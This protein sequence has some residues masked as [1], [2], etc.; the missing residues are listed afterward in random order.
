MVFLIPRSAV[1]LWGGVYVDRLNKRYVMVFT[2]V[3]RAAL[4]A[5]LAIAAFQGSAGILLVY[6]VSFS[7]GLLGA[8]FDLASE[9]ILPSV[10]PAALLLRANS[11]FTAT[12]QVDNI[13]GPAVAGLAISLMGTALPLLF[14]AFSFLALVVALLLMRIQAVAP[15]SQKS[16]WLDD[17]REGWRFFR[18]RPELVW[19]ASLVAGVNFGLGGVWYVYSLIFAKNVLNAG[20]TGWGLI[21]A[22]SALGILASS[23]YIGRVGMKRKRLSVVSSMFGMG[24]AITLLS[25]TQTLPQALVAIAAFG[26]AVPLINVVATTYYQQVVPGSLLGRVIGVRQFIDYVTIPAGIVFGI[27]VAS[28]LG[29]AVGMLISGLVILAFAFASLLGVPLRALEVET[30][31]QHPETP[32]LHP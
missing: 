31:G 25:F 12:F 13:L 7:V 4:F 1:R 9:A 11:V 22:F 20:S 23:V 2:E 28:F 6:A 3:S 18:E 19:L 5:A 17:F 27:L 24:L 29:S 21:N 32:Q 16:R 14:D 26:A 30:G 8:M 15:P 10:V